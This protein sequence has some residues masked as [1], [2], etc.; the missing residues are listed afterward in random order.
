MTQNKVVDI[1]DSLRA[2]IAGSGAAQLLASSATLFEAGGKH[3]L[4]ESP[5]RAVR[6]VASASKPCGWPPNK[7]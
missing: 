1:A 6:E 5:R 7:Y 3:W 4:S 2:A